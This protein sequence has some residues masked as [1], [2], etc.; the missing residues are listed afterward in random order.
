MYP[1]PCVRAQ[2]RAGRSTDRPAGSR[3]LASCR[4]DRRRERSRRKGSAGRAWP[5]ERALACACGGASYSFK[6]I[7]RCRPL[8]ICVHS[9]AAFWNKAS[10]QTRATDNPRH[11]KDNTKTHKDAQQTRLACIGWI[12]VLAEQNYRPRRG[13]WKTHNLVLL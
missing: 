1:P 7:R 2:L 4:R 13:L 10:T 3:A 5:C 6:K 12:L 8:S 9:T 11:Y